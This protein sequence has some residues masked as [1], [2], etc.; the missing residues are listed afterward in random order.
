MEEFGVWAGQL[1]I[2][3]RG[4]ASILS[5]RFPYGRTATVADRGRRRKER[6]EPGAFDFQLDRFAQVAR[7]IQAIQS[8]AVAEVI[9]E[10]R[11]ANTSE[12]LEELQEALERANV[13]ILRGHDFGQP[14]G[15]MK[16]GTARVVSTRE[17]VEFEVDLPSDADMPTYF[18]DALKEIRTNRAGGISP[19]FRMPPSN[20]VPGAEVDIPEPGNPSVSIR[21]IRQAVLYELSIVSRPAYGSTEVDLRAEVH[22][23]TNEGRDTRPHAGTLWL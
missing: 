9:E 21:V 18:S 16:R 1:E 3:Q 12:R 17:A 19:G 2:R 4:G 5:G 23:K 10:Q 7:E 15:D 11:A 14:L 6:I 20:V 8:Q 22:A 13:H